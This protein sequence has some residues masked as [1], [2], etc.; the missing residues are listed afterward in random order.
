VP[1]V[2]EDIERIILM[3]GSLCDWDVLGS[4]FNNLM[5]KHES[6]NIPLINF[7]ADGAFDQAFPHKKTFLQDFASPLKFKD[8][9]NKSVYYNMHVQQFIGLLTS[10]ERN[11]I[12]RGISV[13][14]DLKDEVLAPIFSLDYWRPLVDKKFFS[15]KALDSMLDQ[16]K[17]ILFDNLDS[18]YEV[19][20]C[21]FP[22]NEKKE[23]DLGRQLRSN[24]ARVVKR[25]P[26][27]GDVTNFELLE[28]S[29]ETGIAGVSFCRERKP[30]ALAKPSDQLSQF[31]SVPNYG[32]VLHQESTV[33]HV[34]L[35]HLY[36]QFVIHTIH[37]RWP[38]RFKVFAAISLLDHLILALYSGQCSKEVGWSDSYRALALAIS[39]ADISW[40]DVG[41]SDKCQKTRKDEADSYRL[42]SYIETCGSKSCGFFKFVLPLNKLEYFWNK[43]SGDQPL[44]HQDWDNIECLLMRTRDHMIITKACDYLIK[45]FNLEQSVFS[46]LKLR[47]LAF[48]FLGRLLITDASKQR[49]C[50]Q[51]PALLS[52]LLL[53][54]SKYSFRVTWRYW[55]EDVKQILVWREELKVLSTDFYQGLIETCRKMIAQYPEKRHQ[56]YELYKKTHRFIK[57]HVK[58]CHILKTTLKELLK[59]FEVLDDKSKDGER[60]IASLEEDIQSVEEHAELPFAYLLRRNHVV[61]KNKVG[62]STSSFLYGEGVSPKELPEDEGKPEEFQFSFDPFK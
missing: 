40:L 5:G 10:E 53:Y 14:N 44:D 19:V 41:K 55:A 29:N 38:L 18:I 9:D 32:F 51:F 28:G 4:G 17:K 30:L 25:G 33:H 35:I 61:V 11:N 23:T 13:L 21:L 20:P 59:Q 26:H 48:S 43:L 2:R 22:R 45:G 60:A 56:A 15:E 39:P 34:S 24:I 62:I 3:A 58:H 49:R 37:E 8:D 7:D 27:L 46:R 42:A 57:D 1:V 36:V 54:I 16:Y 50:S 12:Y 6:G 31:E 47:R 52:A